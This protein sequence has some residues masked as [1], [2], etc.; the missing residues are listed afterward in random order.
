MKKIILGFAIVSFLCGYGSVSAYSIGDRDIS[1]YSIDELRAI[2]TQIQKKIE[3]M[4][5]VEKGCFV[6]ESDLSLGDGEAGVMSADVKRLQDF[7]REKKFFDYKST[8]YFGKLTSAALVTYQKSVGV[9]GTGVFDSATRLKVHASSCTAGKEYAVTTEVK[10]P[11]IEKK[12]YEVQK[13]SVSSLGISGSESSV[14]WTVGGYSSQGFKV[15]WSK[16]SG[17]TYPTRS[18]D[19]YYYTSNPG[20]RSAN[21]DAFDGSGTYYVRVCEY[22]GGR[23]GFYSNEI[24]VSL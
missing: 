15:V 23:C 20:D 21:L 10:K 1:S 8:G 9:G 12:Q 7:L 19:K 6:S 2:L 18:T 14:T 22:L 24:K 3:G 4:K 16:T 17:A 11:T 13:G 5:V